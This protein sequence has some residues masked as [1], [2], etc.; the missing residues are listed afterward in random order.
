MIYMCL[1]ATA[2]LCEDFFGTTLKKKKYVR[3]LITA[4][5][6]CERDYEMGPM[7]VH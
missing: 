3:F 1:T 2:T 7:Y 6:C 5:H 4:G